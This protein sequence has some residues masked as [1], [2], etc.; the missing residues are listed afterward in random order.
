MFFRHYVLG[1]AKKM[2]ILK[3]IKLMKIH[4]WDDLSLLV[5]E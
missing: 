5:R 4:L 2:K 1:R 3:Y